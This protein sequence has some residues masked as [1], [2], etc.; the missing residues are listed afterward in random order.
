MNKRKSLARQFGALFVL[1]TLV[2]ILISSNM[3]YLNQTHNYRATC[4][5]DLQK[6]TNHLSGLIEK[7]G[8]EFLNLKKFFAEYT[9]EVLVPMNFR[10]D[11]VH[12]EREFYYYLKQHYP[13]HVFGEDLT[14]DD[15]DHE[16]QRLYVIYR[17]EYWFTV[18]FDAADEFHLSYVYFLY[19][20]EDK[21]YTMNYMFDPT[22]TPLTDEQGNE[23]LDS[24]GN[25]CLFLGDQVYEDP[26][27]H[28]YMWEAWERN[29]APTGF[30]TLNNEFGHVYTYCMPLT[31]SNT[32]VGLVCAEISVAK[33][34]SDI[35][36]SVIRQTLVSLIV[37]AISTLLLYLFI[38][39]RVLNR[40]SWLER[41][42]ETYSE[43]KD[44]AISKE[45]MSR[46][47]QNDEI[48]S[49]AERF[50]GMITELD[51]YMINLQTVTAEKERIG[52]ELSVATQIQTDILPKI[53]PPFEGRND[54]DI[55]ATM[56]P[57]KEVGGDFFDFFLVDDTH[58][59]LVIADVSGK[60]VPAAL[61]MVIAKTLIKNRML[62]GDTPG[63][64]LRNVNEQ[65]CEGND[66]G[67]FVTVWA[68]L[69][70]TETGDGI[71]ANAGHEC[72]AV[73]RSGGDYELIRLRHSPAVATMEGIRYRENSFHMDPGDHLFV[74]TDGVT[75]ATNAN[76]ELF[77]EQRLV[78]A[79]NKHKDKDVYHLLPAVR[80]EIDAF[81]GE[82]P[83]FDDITMLSFY[84]IGKESK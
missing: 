38:R 42:V 11:R 36:N 56:S 68:A 55:F 81:V 79:L 12:S 62:S 6:L 66:T 16:G 10:E 53:F 54:F 59:G 28:K 84:Y 50:S 17:F 34:N 76:Y 26:T 3:T 13:G 61:F 63:E 22:M 58:L 43:E 33:V 77:T 64:A 5:L 52:A 41:E 82:A 49:L 19:P 45:I 35:L 37:L 78:V 1:F 14:F 8:D 80:E 46:R 69:I 23:I 25:N 51:E 65:L 7:E 9:D 40:I 39:M 71:E 30:D 27:I 57:A 31:L 67:F 72:P 18:F 20:Q 60:G 15:L 44:P 73:C 2:T 74:Y 70:N 32:Q 29:K 75:E 21:E 83:Q 4:V 47:G 48:G 24:D